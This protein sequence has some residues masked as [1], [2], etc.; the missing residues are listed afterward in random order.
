MK[1]Q[2]RMRIHFQRLSPNLAKLLQSMGERNAPRGS[3]LNRSSVRSWKK[4]QYKRREKKEG[5]GEERRSMQKIR[6]E[7]LPISTDHVT[8]ECTDR[9]ESWVLHVL[10]ECFFPM[11]YLH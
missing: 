5:R 3:V 4:S 10:F 1:E 7:A 9:K 6:A 11:K 2:R 8:S